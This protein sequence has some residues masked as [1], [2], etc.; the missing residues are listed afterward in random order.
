MT[1][2]R[3]KSP[4]KSLKLVK[5]PQ[6]E[7]L[8]E[9]P[10]KQKKSTSPEPNLKEQRL[11]EEQIKEQKFKQQRMHDVLVLV[12]NLACRE[13]VTIKMILDCLYDVGSVNLINKKFPSRPINKVM[14]SI[15]TMSKPAFKVIGFYWFK[16]NC[17]QLITDWLESKVSF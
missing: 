2:A 8:K 12:E 3:L 10:F 17:P 13:E 9:Q 7:R 11:K 6:Q 15:A 14:K 1:T 4:E 5:P 16:K